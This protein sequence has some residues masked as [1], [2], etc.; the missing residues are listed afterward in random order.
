[1]TDATTYINDAGGRGI[2]NPN[3]QINVIHEKVLEDKV[4]EEQNLFKS[5]YQSKLWL[6]NIELID[7]LID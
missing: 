3:D 5:V 1:M 2:L 6:N 4:Y 7:L